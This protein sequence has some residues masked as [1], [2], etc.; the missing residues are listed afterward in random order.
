MKL[1]EHYASFDEM[2]WPRVSGSVSQ[3][4]WNLKYGNL[5]QSDRR[6]AAS[7]I[8]AYIELVHNKTQKT[9]NKICKVLKEVD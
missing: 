7:V 1:S 2:C 3:I 6:V 4:I 9:R 8:G 5:S